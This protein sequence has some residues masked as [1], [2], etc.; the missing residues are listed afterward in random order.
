MAGALAS[1]ASAAVIATVYV[2]AGRSSGPAS[3]PGREVVERALAVDP[4]VDG[5]TGDAVEHGEL[6]GVGCRGRDGGEGDEGEGPGGDAGQE[7]C[8]HG[9]S[10]EDWPGGYVGRPMC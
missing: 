9:A 10:F 5:Q 7:S 6:G 2:P 8:A 4:D 3:E 1:A